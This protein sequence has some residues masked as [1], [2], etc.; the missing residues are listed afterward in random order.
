MKY[1]LTE[2]EKVNGRHEGYVATTRQCFQNGYSAAKARRTLLRIFPHIPVTLDMVQSFR[3]KRWVPE[4]EL[5]KLQNEAAAAVV[6]AFGG[7]E[8]L[9]NLA[10]AKIHELMSDGKL[11]ASQLLSAKSLLGRFLAHSLKEQE[12][13]LK[14][15][16]LEIGE[17]VEETPEEHE[18]KRKAA[19]LRVVAQIKEI[20]GI[21]PDPEP[22]A[23]IPAPILP[24]GFGPSA[25]QGI[26][27]SDHQV[28]EIG[29]SGHRVIG[30]FEQPGE[31]D[32]SEELDSAKASDEADDG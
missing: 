10:S 23:I 30:S 28:E 11:S 15:G 6:D 12:F 29:S 26:G 20:F 16:Q 7:N 22:Q 19:S 27:P 31:T 24:A 5:L 17:E 8:G 1:V 3:T 4:K 13:L 32:S 25:Q 21:S 2:I 14:T 9:D 18:A